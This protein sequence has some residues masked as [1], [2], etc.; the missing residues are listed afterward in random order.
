MTCQV[1]TLIKSLDYAFVIFIQSQCTLTKMEKTSLKLGAC[2]TLLLDECSSM[3]PIYEETR[4][5]SRFTQNE[6]STLKLQ[7]LEKKCLSPQKNRQSVDARVDTSFNTSVDSSIDGSIDTCEDAAFGNAY[8]NED[9]SSSNSTSYKPKTEYEASIP[10]A[11]IKLNLSN[12]RQ[13]IKIKNTLILCFVH[14]F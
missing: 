4:S 6:D 3:N 1:L 2:P 5:L 9:A 7:D 13:A 12:K 14:T 10:N 8:Q 11:G